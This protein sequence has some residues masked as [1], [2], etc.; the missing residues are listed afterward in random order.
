[1]DLGTAL[2]RVAVRWGATAGGVAMAAVFGAVA[3]LRPAAK[4]LHPT[5]SVGRGVLHRVGGDQPSGIPW[6]DERGED[7]VLV[8]SSR[9]VGLPAPAPDVFGLAVRLPIGGEAYGDLLFASTGRGPLSRFMF[10]PARSPYTRVM[11]TMM[12]FRTS[13]GPMLLLAAHSPD[14][15]VELSWAVGSGP[16][17]R[18]ATLV[19]SERAAAGPDADVSFDSV[20][21]NVPGL[22]IYDWVRRLREPSYRSA[23]R[24]RG[25][26]D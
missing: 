5:G 22:E 16:W 21:N 14:R 7:E 19:M 26:P 12:P 10:T 9:S 24:S 20:R 13:S 1:M 25:L 18:F 17:H 8:R 15:T 6:L 4:P 23:R 3:R 11:T 2:R